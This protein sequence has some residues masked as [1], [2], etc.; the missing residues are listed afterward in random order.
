[1]AKLLRNLGIIA[2]ISGIG[3]IPQLHNNINLISGIIALFIAWFSYQLK[4]NAIEELDK[5][6]F[7][8]FAIAMFTAYCIFLL[9]NVL[10]NY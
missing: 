1:M 8:L 2:I 6:L 7:K 9:N 10:I 5:N 4:N 3:L